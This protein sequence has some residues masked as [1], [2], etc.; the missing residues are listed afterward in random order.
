MY[1]KAGKI[2][3]VVIA[4]GSYA[5]HDFSEM[6]SDKYYVGLNDK[7]MGQV[8]TVLIGREYISDGGSFTLTSGIIGH[9][10]IRGGTSATMV[11]RAIEGFVVA[12][13]IEMPRNLRINVV[14]ASVLKE[15][16][17]NYAK[18]FRGFNPVPAATVALA[19][20]KSVEGLQTGQVYKVF[21]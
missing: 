3:A 13:A 10:P 14:C 12:S 2:D 20:S 1:K 8:N 16:M 4:S 5:F 21:G 6:T 15:A 9:D 18:Y 17:E 11:N 19:Y 7:L